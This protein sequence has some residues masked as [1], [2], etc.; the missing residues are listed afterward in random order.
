VTYAIGPKLLH[1]GDNYETDAPAP[2]QMYPLSL[3]QFGQLAPPAPLPGRFSLANIN[4]RQVLLV[5]VV[6]VVVALLMRQMM[7]LAKNTTKVERNAVVS[8][9]ST[10]ELV[11]RLYDRLESK[12]SK[13]NPAVMR[14]LERL[15]R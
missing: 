10:K 14:S 3:G 1:V 4:I 11:R 5:L 15:G 13:T 2:F 7:K 9:L 8:R 12:G 6:I